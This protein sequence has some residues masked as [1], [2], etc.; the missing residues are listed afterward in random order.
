MQGPYAVP[1]RSLWTRPGIQQQRV[2][3]RID[4]GDVI[5]AVAFDIDGTLYPNTRMY[6]ASWP[7]V[8]RNV[9]LFRAFGTA[10]K[11]VRAERPVANLR[12]R[13]DQLTAALLGR[14]TE[15]VAD[16]I[17]RTIYDRW[18]S[19]LSRVR[20]YDGA[21]ELLEW[22]QAQDVPLA[23][24]SDFPV[25]RKLALLGIDEFW[26]IA[27]SSE[28]TG[29]LKPNPE[30]FLRLIEELNVPADQILYVGNSYRYDIVGARS[31][32]MM[33]AH[34]THRHIKDRP[35]DFEFRRFSQLRRWLEGKIQR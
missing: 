25:Q 19:S 3:R 5:R 29:Y 23:A 6:R 15:S 2:E 17:D 20:L 10:R 26:D 11:Q 12:E 14:D 22:L 30:P 7:I 34:I 33:T 32:G 1:L 21:R 4:I 16:D 8:V 13:T 24:V 28:D 31:C 18:E 9:S 35:A 27:F